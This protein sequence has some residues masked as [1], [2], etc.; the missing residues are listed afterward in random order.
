MS[1]AFEDREKGFEAKYQLDQEALFRVNVRRDKLLGLW[2]A[3]R[4][5]LE[6][7]E[8]EA[9]ARTVVEADFEE[10]G[11]ADVVRKVL[12]D[13]GERGIQMEEDFLRK[14]M[15]KLAAVARDQIL[16]EAGKG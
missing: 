6:G 16:K 9:Y 8:A 1:N 7:R 13:L 4:I 12:K 11:D 14:Q 3:E 15:D 2:A 10:P 5:G